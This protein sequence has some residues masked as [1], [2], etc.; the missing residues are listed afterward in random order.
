MTWVYRPTTN[1][2]SSPDRDRHGVP[3]HGVSAPASDGRMQV[4]LA[5]GDR[6][7]ASPAELVLELPSVPHDGLVGRAGLGHRRP[8]G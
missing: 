4:V 6:I 5:N 3:V 7:W 2:P 1:S 8:P